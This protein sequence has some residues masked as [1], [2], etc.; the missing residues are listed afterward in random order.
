MALALSLGRRG[1]GTTWP[2]PSVGCVIV[3]SGRIVGRGWTAPSGRPHAETQALAQAGDAARGATAYVTLE[4]CAHWGQTPP[5]AGALAAAGVAR[6]VVAVGDSDPRV[7][8]RGITMLRE[9]GLE[10]ECG[11]LEQEARH[12]HM[13][14]FSRI[15]RGRPMITLKLAQ[16]FDG[17]I[18]TATGESKWITQ[19]PAR[20]IVHAMRANHDAVVVGG[21]TLRA[22]DPL[23]DVRD[24]GVRTQPARIVVSRHLDIPFTSRLAQTAAVTPLVLCHG[25]EAPA[26]LVQAW[27]DLGAQMLVCRTEGRQLDMGDVTQ[28][29]GLYGLTRVFCE[30][31]SAIAASL[32]SADLVDHL[33]GFT[34]GI[35]IGA[36]GLPGVGAMG[37]AQLSQ[38][39]R[40]DLVGTQVVGPDI[41]HRWVRNSG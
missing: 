6:V 41:T 12:D 16:S 32:L 3:S 38:A 31:G 18:A 4:P 24:M 11:L 29:L 22:D 19:A 35:A 5:C 1:W 33:V 7:A 20:R 27:R 15:E 40:F 8:G 17:R 26:G 28:Q 2:N 37:L 23:L 9:A 13:G 21:G 25:P 36:E 30:G 14:F 39:P 10:V 34:S